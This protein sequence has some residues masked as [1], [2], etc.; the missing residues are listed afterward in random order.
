[1]L[2]GGL[3]LWVRTTFICFMMG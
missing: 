3:V 2:F 1:V